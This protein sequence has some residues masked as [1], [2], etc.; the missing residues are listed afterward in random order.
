MRFAVSLV[1]TSLILAVSA[2]AQRSPFSPPQAKLQYAPDRTCDL[3][4]LAVD[5]DIDYPNRSFS[6]KSVNTL[7]PLRAGIQEILLHAGTS[8]S[9]TS[10]KVNGATAKYRQEGKNLFIATGPLAK[11]KPF[12]VEIAYTSK[13]SRGTGFGSGGG[14]F[15]WISPNATTPTRV[16]FWTQ[17]ETAYNCEWAPTWDYPNDL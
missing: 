7:S 12:Q 17:G 14:G 5:I 10:V 8:L 4:H 1:T 6:G 13:N 16:G 9:L 11:G 3:Q 15:H 2:Q